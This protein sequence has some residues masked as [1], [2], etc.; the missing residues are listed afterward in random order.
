M[1]KMRK[2]SIILLL[3]A[4]LAAAGCGGSAS[5]ITGA[6]TTCTTNCTSTDPVTTV[7]VVSN[8]ATI[9]ADGS[10]SAT[11]SATAK[12]ANN[13]LVTG[14]TVTF[15]ASA[16]GLAVTQA[17][18]DANGLATAT[19]TAGSAAAGT[20]IT[21]TATTEGIS[22]K[23]TVAIGNVQQTISVITS[24]P[25]IPSDSSKSATITALVRNA[26]NQFVSG[27]AVAFSAT[28]GGLTVTQATTGTNGAATA[29][30]SAAGDPTNRSIT[31]T[32][33]AGS[34]TATV[35]VAV[36][37]TSLTV[38]GPLSL[39]QG[40]VGTY[41][42][43]LTDAGGTG[44]PN[45]AVTLASA[46]GNT[47]SGATVTTNATGEST[48]TLTAVNGGTDVIT[49]ASLGLQSTESVAVS[50]QDFAFTSPAAAN[51]PVNIGTATTVT[52]LWLSGGKAQAGQTVTFS[53]TRGAL[54]V[55]S[56][57]VAGDGTASVEI[58]STTAGPSVI[59][60]TGAGVTA[61]AT[62]E[63]IATMP[64]QI[65][66][67]ASPSI[68]AA[69]GQSTL[70]ATVRDANNNLVEGQ[71][72]DFSITKDSTGGSLS[73]PSAT[74][75]VQG[76]AS[77]VYTAS[78]TT[79]ASN[80][81]TVSATVAD[82]TVSSSATLTVGG[83]SVFLSLGTGNVVAAG[84]NI[85]TQ[86]SYP[87]TAQAIDSS[88]AGVSNVT[89]NFTVTS[90]GY[91]KGVDVYNTLDS[92]WEPQV[93]TSA[94]DPDVYILSGLHG[95]LSEDLNGNGILT[96]TEDYNNNGKLDPGLVVATDV[97]SAT[98]GTGGSASVNLIYPKDHA[99]WVAVKLTA[100]AT[101]SGNQSSTSTSFWL[102]GLAS[103]FSSPTQV[104]PGV[105]SPYGQASTCLNPN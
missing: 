92:A 103:D 39:V 101:V 97:S 91:A 38:T 27:V 93:S 51:T 99:N 67:Q 23:A 34:A 42:V 22:G 75:N 82:T 100:T 88:G 30:L 57:T 10:N 43:T 18:T 65:A 86:Y 74:T 60:A 81:I 47:L 5:S 53:A 58:S 66:V 20:S 3:G 64:T 28:S 62:L 46:K 36:I 68:I 24:L 16:G 48:F 71:V 13:N 11:I 63:F 87:F 85:N 12:D 44:I 45:Q 40:S 76:Q 21:V 6:G 54:S 25:Q 52:V 98:T 56:A 9:A 90:L 4:V 95:C 105:N 102:P 69:Q 32:V 83:Q 2:L 41:N 29:T 78:T 31:V 19:L 1:H 35:P 61:Q 73:L 59:S 50:T 104:P 15:S 26:Q 80:G 89:V 37:G 49:A 70:T 33:T 72:V 14:A 17:T 7:S 94:T 84:P 79:S 96:P 8:L 55:T 77:T